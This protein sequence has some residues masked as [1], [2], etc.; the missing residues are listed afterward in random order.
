MEKLIDAG[1]DVDAEDE[2]EK[3]GHTPLQIAAMY[4]KVL[5]V[6][7]LINRGANVSKVTVNGG[8]ALHHL[9]VAES[10]ETMLEIIELLHKAKADFNIIDDD[11][12]TPLGT[13]ALS[14]ERVD[15]DF[16]S[17]DAARLKNVVDKMIKFGA[18]PLLVNMDVLKVS[19]HPVMFKQLQ[20]E[21]QKIHDARTRLML[22]MASNPS[23][24]NK[25][26]QNEK[27]QAPEMQSASAEPS[28]VT[29]F[30]QAKRLL[31]DVEEMIEKAPHKRQKLTN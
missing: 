29:L 8:T 7:L 18:D 22:V 10:L 25:Y 20:E 2:L 1:A 12:N 27:P 26:K 30:W 15:I 4:S 23:Y 19:G 16:F 17:D 24:Y 21:V 9:C 28:V 3:R 13:F 5:A 11:G 14:I 31:S 6:K